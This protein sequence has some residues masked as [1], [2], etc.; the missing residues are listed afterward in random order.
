MMEEMWGALDKMQL[1]SPDSYKELVDSSV[2]YTKLQATQAEPELCLR[3]ATTAGGQVWCNLLSWAAVSAPDYSQ[4]TPSLPLAGGILSTSFGKNIYSVAVHPTVLREEGVLVSG[5]QLANIVGLVCKFLEQQQQ[6]LHL[7]QGHSLEEAKLH[8]GCNL[9]AIRRELR[10]GG[11]K[12]ELVT[13]S[14]S[15]LLSQLSEV[16]TKEEEDELVLP[17]P[18]TPGTPLIQEIKSQEV[19]QK[20]G[21]FGANLQKAFNPQKPRKEAQEEPVK[22][23]NNEV[24]LKEVTSRKIR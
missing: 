13:T 11:G 7:L 3:L 19:T 2:A 8:P 23:R 6:H 4:D 10:P 21:T 15:S 17:A 20:S 18:Q 24:F 5:E 9:E 16:C 22:I 1:A 12:T 14:P